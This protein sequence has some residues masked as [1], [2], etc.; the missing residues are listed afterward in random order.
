MPTRAF[1]APQTICNVSPPALTLQTRRR[2]ASGCC[3]ASKISATTT[4]VK[5]GAKGRVSSTSRPA[6]VKACDN[7]SVVI[8]GLTY[9]LS[10]DSENCIVVAQSDLS[11]KLR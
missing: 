7:C 6:M 1:G 9:C 10:Q 8:S 2:S 3:A 11:W 4:C 5:G